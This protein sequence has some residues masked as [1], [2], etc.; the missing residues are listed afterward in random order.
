MPVGPH[1]F[2]ILTY[3]TPQLLRIQRQYEIDLGLAAS[4]EEP[5]DPEMDEEMD[6]SIDL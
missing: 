2:R 5:M 4:E 1:Y 6:D 3:S